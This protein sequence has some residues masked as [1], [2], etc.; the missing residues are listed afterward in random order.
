MIETELW[1]PVPFD[2]FC[3]HYEVSTLG[4]IRRR[5]R[6]Y[7][8]SPIGFLLTP[9]QRKSCGGHFQVALCSGGTVKDFYVHRLVLTAFV[10]PCPDGMQACHNDGNPAN[11]ALSNLRW[12]SVKANR[13]DARRHGTM[14][15][16][17]RHHMAK[18]TEDEVREVRNLVAAG[19]TQLSLAK[20]F[21]VK[22]SVICNMVKRKTWKHV[23]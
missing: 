4:R 23:A 8:G 15:R 20:R 22:A 18:F 9:K 12:D 17:S 14:S 11:N 16:G 21:G 10:G 2:G 19:V 3:N 6:A 13:A 7:T 1:V 5:T